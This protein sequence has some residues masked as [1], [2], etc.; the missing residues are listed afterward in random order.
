[1]K[2]TIGEV[3]KKQ[4]EPRFDCAF[5]RTEGRPD[6]S[7]HAPTIYIN[8]LC[9]FVNLQPTSRVGAPEGMDARGLTRGGAQSVAPAD[10]AKAVGVVHSV[11]HH[12]KLFRAKIDRIHE[13]ND[14]LFTDLLH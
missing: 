14:S 8:E 13:M 7:V 1:M 12:C 5:A 10:V 6:P 9:K 11:V 3:K 4:P 2:S